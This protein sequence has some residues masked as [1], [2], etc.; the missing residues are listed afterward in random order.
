MNE[1][2]DEF[3]L[4]VT[5]RETDGSAWIIAG[6]KGSRNTLTTAQESEEL[7]TQVDLLP[8][9]I[10]RDESESHVRLSQQ[11]RNHL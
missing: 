1:P 8:L 11:Q 2:I 5:L 4:G 3:L 6:Q 9:T 10:I 7:R